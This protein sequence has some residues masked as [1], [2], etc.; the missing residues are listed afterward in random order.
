MISCNVFRLSE[1]RFLHNR[2]IVRAMISVIIP[3]LN[4]ESQLPR[5]L[6]A[7]V[8]AAGLLKEVII[9][10][11][12]STDATAGI[13]DGCGAR[14]VAAAAGRGP[15]LAA[16]AATAQG[17]WLLFLHADTELAPE[18]ETEAARFIENE[19]ASGQPVRAGFFRFALDD[20][21]FG[22][23]LMERGVALRA[24]VL[25]LPYGDQGLLIKHSH[26]RELGGFRP[27]PLMEDVDM[28]RRIGRRR[29]KPLRSTVLTSAV[30]YRREGYIRRIAR[31]LTCLTLYFLRVRPEHIARLYG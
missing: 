29:L 1:F 15:Q 14:F 7:L 31:N 25:G 16:G 9:A 20:P 18:W 17:D 5:C 13:A 12:G 2:I 10:D 8:P 30:R 23:R 3:T 11:G 26:Y 21:G 28:V 24:G 22:P 19:I 27:L 6:S 4:A